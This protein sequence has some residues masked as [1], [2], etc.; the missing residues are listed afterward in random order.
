MEIKEKDIPLLKTDTSEIFFDLNMDGTNGITKPDLNY[1]N[2]TTNFYCIF[3]NF[4][5]MYCIF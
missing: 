3:Y 2:H 1:Y 4:T 5:V